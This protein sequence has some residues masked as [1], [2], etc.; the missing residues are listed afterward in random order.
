M[1]KIRIRTIIAQA[2]NDAWDKYE[3][4]GNEFENTTF[5]KEFDAWYDASVVALD[6]LDIEP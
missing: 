2:V 3:L 5:G 1:T 4:Y 6:K